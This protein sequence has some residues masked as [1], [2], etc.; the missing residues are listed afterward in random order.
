VEF[1]GPGTRSTGAKRRAAARWLVW[2]DDTRIGERLE[3]RRQVGVDH[4]PVQLNTS[5]DD[6]FDAGFRLLA[7]IL[8]LPA[9]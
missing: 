4:G 8:G 1:K 6:E 9:R 7:E 2:G 3:A 5:S